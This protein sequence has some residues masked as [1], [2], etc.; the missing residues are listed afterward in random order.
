[1][2]EIK[3][4]LGKA[5]PQNNIVFEYTPT[6]NE[7]KAVL[8]KKYSLPVKEIHIFSYSWDEG[9][10]LGGPDP[11]PGKKGVDDRPQERRLLPEDLAEYKPHHA[12]P[13][14]RPQ[15]TQQTL[16]ALGVGRK[17]PGVAVEGGKEVLVE[18]RAG[19][20]RTPF[21]SRQRSAARATIWLAALRLGNTMSVAGWPCS[22]ASAI[23][24]GFIAFR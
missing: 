21:R 19:H 18:E 1:M 7:L 16:R 3:A 20:H 5:A 10:N 11:G 23:T 22:A 6:E 2:R 12:N 17:P 8:N 13:A 14:A 24:F 9:V 15:V 4:R